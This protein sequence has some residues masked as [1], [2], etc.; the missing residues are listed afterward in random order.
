MSFGRLANYTDNKKTEFLGS[1]VRCWIRSFLGP[2][3]T[4]Y[5]SNCNYFGSKNRE[6]CNSR[7]TRAK[8]ARNQP[9]QALSWAWC[10]VTMIPAKH[11]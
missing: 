6:D 7:P 2:G 5:A 9:S 1:W 3:E 8:K 11:M 10:Y 4:T